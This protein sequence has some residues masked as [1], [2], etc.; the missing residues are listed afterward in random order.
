MGTPSGSQGGSPDRGLGWEPQ[1]GF[2]AAAL[3]GV[4]GG[5][6]GGKACCQSHDFPQLTLSGV[7][8]GGREWSAGRRESGAARVPTDYCRLG[9]AADE[10]ADVM[11]SPA[12]HVNWRD[13]TEVG[14]KSA[15]LRGVAPSGVQP[16]G[17]QPLFRSPKKSGTAAAV[18]I[19][20]RVLNPAGGS[21]RGAPTGVWG[22]NPKQ[23]SGR[24]P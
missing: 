22:G 23:V 19:R 18:P 11:Q 16:K 1:A 15:G 12:G 10:V 21:G 14:G 6:P 20:C 7:S 9:A 13:E 24:Q 17:N 8:A 4:R 2:R 3:T 5:S